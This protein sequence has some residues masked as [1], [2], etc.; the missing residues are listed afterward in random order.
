MTTGKSIQAI[1]IVFMATVV[2]LWLGVSIVTA[3]TQTLMQIVVVGGIIIGL[4]LGRKIW[5]LFIFLNAINIPLINGLGS[6]ELG[7][8]ALIGFTMLILLI[9]RQ[10]LNFRFTELEAWWLLLAAMITQVYLRHP[11]GLN[12]FGSDTVGAKPYFTVGVAF[13]S[14]LVLGNLVVPAKE[15]KWSM[16]ITILGW[17]ASPVLLRLRT[18]GGGGTAAYEAGAYGS[19]ATATRSEAFTRWGAAASKTLAAFLSPLRACFHPIWGPLILLSILMAALSGFRNN[20]AYVGLCYL[21][22]MAYRGGFISILISFTLGAFGIGALALVNLAFPLPANVQRALSPFP[23]TW[24]ERYVEDANSS[25]QW[26]LD[27]WKEAIFTDYW[28]KNKWIGD[29]LGMTRKELEYLT[30]LKEG[31]ASITR[32]HESNLV[33]D[34]ESQMIVGGY[35]SG[36]VQCVRV[37]GYIG[38]IVVLLA[39]IRTAVHAH[40]QIMRCR[41]TEWYPLSLFYGIPIIAL[42]IFYTLVIGDFGRD[43]SFLL[44]SIGMIRLLEKNLPL[45]PYVIRKREPYQLTS[46]RNQT[47]TIEN[48]KF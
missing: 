36:P 40:R 24:E 11:A 44:I 17:F 42:P 10:P 1:V 13:I 35:H 34:Q 39:M 18:G 47:A 30:S 45:P 7:Q 31:A 15:I 25:T 26:R 22:A 20:V 48:V 16:W 2:S 3:Q 19:E 12:M 6:S 43:V 27:M 38:F 9:R 4:L 33:A 21:I 8:M 41:G 28:I 32:S 46:H 23:G 14:S 37:I 29:G 5:L